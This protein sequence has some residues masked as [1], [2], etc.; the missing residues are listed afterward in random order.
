MAELQLGGKVIATQSGANNPVLA[1]NVVMD[2]VN[3]N[4]ALASATFPAGH[5]I[6]THYKHIT[7]TYD[8]SMNSDGTFKDLTDLFIDV[9]TIASNSIFLFQFQG[10]WGRPTGNNHYTIRLA[11]LINNANESYPVL[12]DVEGTRPRGTGGFIP[13]S[14]AASNAEGYTSYTQ[15]ID[16][17]T[18]SVGDVIRYKLQATVNT[19]N[20]TIYL[21][22]TNLFRDGGAANPYDPMA[23]SSIVV[24]EIAQ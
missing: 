6:K 11:R 21:N 22:K 1:S 9:T 23:T 2:N 19:T 24:M 13:Q 18:Y 7:D 5:V 14:A 8:Y 10:A 17:P 4:N 3:V 20:G 12:T 15:I 16:A